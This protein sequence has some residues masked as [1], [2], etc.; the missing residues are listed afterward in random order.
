ME[1]MLELKLRKNFNEFTKSL[2]TTIYFD[3]IIQDE[4]GD[5]KLKIYKKYKHLFS[6]YKTIEISETEAMTDD[7]EILSDEIKRLL[8]KNFG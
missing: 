2:F 5:F 7:V 1:N 8:V 4:N 6:E 3:T